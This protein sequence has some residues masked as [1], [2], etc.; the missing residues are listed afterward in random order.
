[1]QQQEGMT[2]YALTLDHWISDPLDTP[3]PACS[4]PGHETK[5]A[6]A[7]WITDDMR[8]DSYLCMACLLGAQMV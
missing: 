6:V 7:V 3:G 8:A 2:L 5:Q 4:T 1:M